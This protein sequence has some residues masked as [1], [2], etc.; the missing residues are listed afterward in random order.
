MQLNKYLAYA[1][2]AS[3]R[4]AVQL[5]KTGHVSVNGS[6]VNDPG[7]RV[8]D[9]AVVSIDG[10][11]IKHE[12][13]LYILLNKPKGYVTTVSDELGRHTVMDLVRPSIKERLYPVGRLDKDTTGLLILTNDGK[14][15]QMFAHPRYE[16]EKKYAVVLDRPLAV[17]DGA[18]IYKGIQ[19]G[20]GIV[21]VDRLE[22]VRYKPRNNLIVT[23]HSGKNRVIRR[24]FQALGYGV[25]KL[26]RFKYAGLTKQGLRLG[27]WRFLKEKEVAYLRGKT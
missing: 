2:I 24:L 10:K 19:L 22:F 4:K 18:Q 20:D 9:K 27:S 7:F 15:A 26:D 3:R 8:V 17:E 11:V 21:K 12:R 25:L 13:K 5:I 23:L 16:V 6:V 14:L 1:G